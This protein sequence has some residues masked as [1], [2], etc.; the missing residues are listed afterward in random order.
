MFGWLI[1]IVS[2]AVIYK[3]WKSGRKEDVKEPPLQRPDW[4]KDVVYLVQFPVSPKV[5]SISPFSVKLETWLRMTGIPYEN[6]YSGKMSKKGQVPFI[7][8]NGKQIPDSNL[9]IEFLKTYFKDANPKV[10]QID[11]G[12]T[13]EQS[14]IAHTTKMMMENHTCLAG[15]YYRYVLN[16][17]EF[18]LKMIEPSKDAFPPI[19]IKFFRYVTPKIVKLRLY[20]HGLGRHSPQE[21]AEFSFQDLDAISK[22]LGTKKFYLGDKPSTIDCTLFGHLIQFLYIPMDFPQKAHMTE[23]CQNIV[24]YVERMREEFWPD[25]NE[26]SQKSCMIAKQGKK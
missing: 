23:H 12:L 21:I 7:E 5:R 11:S 18:F 26:E 20:L 8:M 6:I 19:G 15:F 1:G 3:F 13:P 25:W 22:I 17:P 10:L 16:M 9:A 4:K 14:G 2:L 24:D